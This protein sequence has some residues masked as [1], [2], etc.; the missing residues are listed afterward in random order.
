MPLYDDS[1]KKS[2]N[3]PPFFQDGVARELVIDDK[4][5]KIGTKGSYPTFFLRDVKTGD[6]VNGLV[7]F[8]FARSLSDLSDQIELGKTVLRVTP[9]K[10]GDRTYRGVTSD[11]FWFTVEIA[12][13]DAPPKPEQKVEDID[14]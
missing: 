5:K 2:L 8:D 12:G 1:E 4:V 7:D 10:S 3:P 14:F 13:Q 6:T 11:T 9:T